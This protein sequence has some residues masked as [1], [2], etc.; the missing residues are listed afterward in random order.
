V[1][2][3]ETV[4]KKREKNVFEMKGWGFDVWDPRLF[5]FCDGRHQR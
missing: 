2:V 5:R 1:K 4:G 3:K